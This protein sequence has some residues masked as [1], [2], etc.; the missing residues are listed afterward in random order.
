MV[1]SYSKVFFFFDEYGNSPDMLLLDTLLILLPDSDRR[2]SSSNCGLP[3]ALLLSEKYQDA[4][5][6]Q[7]ADIAMEMQTNPMAACAVNVHLV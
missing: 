1:V 6:V 4:L 3:H 5:V 7:N 2:T